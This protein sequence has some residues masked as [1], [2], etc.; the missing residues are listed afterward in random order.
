MVRLTFTKKTNLSDQQFC[1][2]PHSLI[3]CVN[4]LAIGSKNNT[5][6]STYLAKNSIDLVNRIET[7]EYPMSAIL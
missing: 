7:V 3:V 6:K 2:S 4:I 1:M 5:N